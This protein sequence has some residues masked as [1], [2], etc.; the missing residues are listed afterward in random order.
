MKAKINS[1]SALFLQCERGSSASGGDSVKLQDHLRLISGVIM[2][3]PPPPRSSSIT[4]GPNYIY[5]Y[6]IDTEPIDR[7][8]VA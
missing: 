8:H 7:R 4:L 6:I 5:Q 3:T 1:T 2:E